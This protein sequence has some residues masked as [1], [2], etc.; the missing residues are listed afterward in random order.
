MKNR[1]NTNVVFF[2]IMG[3]MNGIFISLIAS[4]IL[5]YLVS[6][7]LF[8]LYFTYTDWLF[9][10][11]PSFALLGALFNLVSAIFLYGDKKLHI[12]KK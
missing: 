3:A 4:Y 5:N 6:S 7:Y 12:E 11:A 8:E 10:F 9:V 1:I 2:V